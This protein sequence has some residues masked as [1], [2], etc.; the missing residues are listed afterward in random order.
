MLEMRTT[1]MHRPLAGTAIFAFAL[2]VTMAV[3][4]CS[5]DETDIWGSPNESVTPSV[6]GPAEAD[7][8]AV[9]KS[10]PV[11]PSAQQSDGASLE[12]GYPAGGP[13][14]PGLTGFYVTPEAVT[15]DDVV[16][17]FETELPKAGWEKAAAPWTYGEEG[18]AT[19][20]I[21]FSFSNADKS[22]RLTITVP[23][24]HKDLPRGV[25]VVNLNITPKDIDPFASPVGPGIDSTPPPMATGEPGGTH[26]P[27]P[28]GTQ[29]PVSE[30]IPVPTSTR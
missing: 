14:A 4:A 25:R 27:R 1:M 23:L 17:F 12:A 24:V 10:L 28:S 13:V 16:S 11:F 6:P 19:E 5:T 8:T 2:L 18:T 7:I 21:V 26:A 29:K 9:L 15:V 20:T 30:T 3:A 22:L